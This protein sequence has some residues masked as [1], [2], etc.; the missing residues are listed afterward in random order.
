MGLGFW[1]VIFDRSCLIDADEEEFP[2]NRKCRMTL[3]TAAV[4]VRRRSAHLFPSTFCP[5]FRRFTA[6]LG[7]TGRESL[8]CSAFAPLLSRMAQSLHCCSDSG[9]LDLYI[10]LPLSMPLRGGV[11]EAVRTVS[12][13]S[14]VRRERSHILS[15]CRADYLR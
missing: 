15:S 6:S 7:S 3:Q 10:E 11:D 1:L 13:S 2:K 5:S 14:S 9:V 8:G 4:V 12:S